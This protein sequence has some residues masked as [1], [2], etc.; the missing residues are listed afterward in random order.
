MTVLILFALVLLILLAVLAMAGYL[1]KIISQLVILGGIALLMFVVY[2]GL[3]VAG[4][5]FMGLHHFGG[6]ELLPFSRP[7]AL[8]IG[9]SVAIILLRKIGKE[10]LAFMHKMEHKLNH[11]KSEPSGRPSPLSE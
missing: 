4:I 10:I 11:H 8:G 5:S 3:L 6:N 1:L 7:L 9:L 2:T